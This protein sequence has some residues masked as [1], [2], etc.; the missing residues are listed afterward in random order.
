MNLKEGYPYWLIKSGL[1][2]NYP[3]LDHVLK[4]E[5]LIIGGGISGALSAWFLTMAGVECTVVDARTI[6]MG[7]TCASTSLLQY[8]LDKPLCELSKIIGDK[9]ANR[10]YTMCYEAIDGLN[11]IS[12]KIKFNEFENHNSL[13]FA[14]EKQDIN[15]IERE[16]K[17][18]MEA[19]IKVELLDKKDI[20]KL[21]EFSAPAAILSSQGAITNA[22]MYT[23]ALHKSA[24]AKGLKVYDRTRITSKRYKKDGVQ[25]NTKQGYTIHAKKVINATGYEVTEFINKKI[26]KLQ[27][28]YALASE[29][30]REPQPVWKTGVMLWNTAKPYLYMRLTSDN[31]VIIGGRDENFYDPEARD[32]MLK[33]KTRLLA[34]DFMKL[35]PSI[36]LI[37]EYSWTGTFGSTKDS[38]PYIGTYSKTP[39][40]YYALGFGGNGIVFSF[41]AAEII[42]D[43]ILGKPNKD[44]SLF[45][46]DR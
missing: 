15:L 31:R 44:S 25:L 5:V 27:S 19:G 34:K 22:Y 37:P 10:V 3:K 4:T 39:H 41:L 2:V 26:V 9:K 33:N 32:K 24:M 42:R 16:Y 20:K 43:M 6:G 12:K 11:S 21:Y 35:F 8:E 18:R 40:T 28:T 46:F 23:H 17:A 7:S 13:Y 36:E 1:P 38:L 45:S 14:A 29:N 30:I